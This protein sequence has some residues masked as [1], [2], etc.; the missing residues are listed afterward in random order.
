MKTLKNILLVNFLAVVLLHALVSHRHHGEMTVGEHTSAH[1][2]ATRLIDYIGLSFH[3]E[4][5]LLEGVARDAGTIQKDYPGHSDAGALKE[6]Y[7]YI[8]PVFDFSGVKRNI[9]LPS[10]VASLLLKPNPRRGPPSL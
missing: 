10:L 5:I 1:R 3:E 7:K 2:K 8:T 6:T 9:E 4:L